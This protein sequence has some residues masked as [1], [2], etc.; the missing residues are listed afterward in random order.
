MSEPCGAGVQ[1]ESCLDHS[2]FLAGVKYASQHLIMLIIPKLQP[3]LWLETEQRQ[4][5]ISFQRAT[6]ITPHLEVPPATLG[7]HD[8]IWGW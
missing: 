5:D 6:S 8:L 2:D 4:G 3:Q 7:F 1:G